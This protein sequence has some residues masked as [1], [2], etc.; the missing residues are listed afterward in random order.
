[1]GARVTTMPISVEAEGRL[2]RIAFSFLLK[3]VRVSVRD[4]SSKRL[5][6][7]IGIESSRVPDLAFRN[8]VQLR[9][10]RA[11]EEN[12]CGGRK[13]T[14]LVVPV[15]GDYFDSGLW[16]E[17]LK[18]L[19]DIISVDFPNWNVSLFSM[20]L[21]LEGARAG[22]DDEAVNYLESLLPE[23]RVLG[24]DTVATY[25]D[26]CS[27][28]R[29]EIDLVV[30]ARMHAGIAALCSAVPLVM[31]GYEEKHRSLMEF[32]GL[33]DQF[34]DLAELDRSMTRGLIDAALAADSELLQSIAD[35]QARD[36][37]DWKIW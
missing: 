22:F 21:S 4:N 30:S 18:M 13:P 24:R 6:A 34:A 7:T 3:D 27:K 14:M 5:L 1:M 23:A 26:L 31:L 2:L 10:D 28:I 32:I 33:Q 19:A 17:K 12:R 16:R 36:L 37:L 8:G 15:G 11:T 9:R 35:Q 29:S 25:S 20:H